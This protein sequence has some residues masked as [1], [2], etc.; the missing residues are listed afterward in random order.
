[1]C[2]AV[3]LQG[4]DQD[5]VTIIDD[6]CDAANGNMRSLCQ[7]AGK[8]SVSLDVDLP[9]ST[10]LSH[11]VRTHSRVQKIQFF[12]NKAKSDWCFSHFIVFWVLFGF[13]LFIFF[14]FIYFI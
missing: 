2:I 9:N 3:L 7:L 6:S 4:C 5:I 1:V 12:I 10:H 11:V 14:L 8:L 13:Y